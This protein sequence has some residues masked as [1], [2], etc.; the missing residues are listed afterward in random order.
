MLSLE[1]ASSLIAEWIFIGADEARKMKTL[2]H[3]GLGVGSLTAEFLM[4]FRSLMGVKNSEGCVTARAEGDGNFKNVL[5][6]FSQ[7]NRSE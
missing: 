2:I 6:S 1:V 3:F 4:F 7:P 5:L